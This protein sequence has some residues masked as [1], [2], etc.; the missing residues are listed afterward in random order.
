[1][2]CHKEVGV[3]RTP[4]CGQ[5]TVNYRLLDYAVQPQKLIAAKRRSDALK[6]FM[7][8]VGM[9]PYSSQSYD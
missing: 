9:P 8:M 2:A 6:L 1:M 4:V 7:T 5:M 3:V